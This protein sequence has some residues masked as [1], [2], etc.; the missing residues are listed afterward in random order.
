MASLSEMMAY[1]DYA[2]RQK[3]LRNPLQLA[4]ESLAG[5]FSQGLEDERDFNISRRKAEAQT[6]ILLDRARQEEKLKNDLITERNENIFR[7]MANQNLGV[8]SAPN[9]AASGKLV[10]ML[11]AP[12]KKGASLVRNKVELDYDPES[13]K[14]G[15]KIKESSPLELYSQAAKEFSAGNLS[16]D[17][18]L[19]FAVDAGKYKD[20]VNFAAH[21]EYTR[22]QDSVAT[23]EAAMSLVGGGE[24]DIYGNP[25]NPPNEAKSIVPPEGFMVN[26]NWEV[27]GEGDVFIPSVIEERKIKS[28]EREKKEKAEEQSKAAKAAMEAEK[29]SLAVD[30]TKQL[31]KTVERVEGKNGSRMKYF[32][33]TGWVPPAPWDSDRIDWRNNYN[34]LISQ[35]TLDKIKELRKTSA[36]GASGMG[37]M[38]DK[39]IALLMNAATA[40]KRVTGPEDAKGYLEDIKAALRKNLVSPTSWGEKYS[41][42]DVIPAE[43]VYQQ[44]GQEMPEGA[45][46]AFKIIGFFPDGEPDVDGIY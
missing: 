36:T 15:I 34:T 8:S 1:A 6:K 40:L 22:P 33:A 38:S 27:T 9:K 14:A 42:G 37:V 12:A 39:D 2:R 7:L 29:R 45:P 18:F 3:E 20:A 21:V 10:S 35:L 11:D 17:D 41:I 5:G 46:K 24:G 28:E 4:V 13:G 31:L 23:P 16:K 26:P 44:Y 19:G 43:E 30:F 32:G 25:I